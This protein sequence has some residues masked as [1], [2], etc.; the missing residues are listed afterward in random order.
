MDE[1]RMTNDE[2]EKHGISQTRELDKVWM[3]DGKR[4]KKKR[5]FLACI[6]WLKGQG[7][8]VLVQVRAL[9]LICRLKTLNLCQSPH[10]SH[11]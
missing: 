11:T 8:V 1:K 6:G 5:I 9:L 3:N 10:A 2:S 4:K 7:R